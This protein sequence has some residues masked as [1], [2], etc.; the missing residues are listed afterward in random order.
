MD[1]AGKIKQVNQYKKCIELRNDDRK[2]G[3][4]SY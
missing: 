2:W 1:F 4:K 3:Q